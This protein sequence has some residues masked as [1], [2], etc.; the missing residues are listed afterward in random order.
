[1][2]EDVI[3]FDAAAGVFV[4]PRRR[5]CA[6]V[7]QRD[8]LFPHMSVRRNLAF[9]DWRSH[10]LERTRRVAEMLER[11]GLRAAAALRPSEVSPGERLRAELARALLASPK[12]LAIDERGL[13]QAAL[14]CVREIFSGPALVVTSDLDFC[15]AIAGDLLLLDGGKILQAG[16]A[17]AVIDH[18]ASVAAARLLGIP[19]LFECVVTALDPGRD[20]SRLE[21]GRFALAGPYLPGHFRGDRVTAAVR[22]DRVRV[23]S[24]EAERSANRVA[25]ELIRISPG[26]R[27][28]RLEFSGGIVAD[29]SHEEFARQKDNK[30]WQVEIP[31]EALRVV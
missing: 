19:N 28:V 29:V 24:G 17:R 1:L 25:A 30:S 9:A 13:D 18:P 2:L 7:P 27:H 26:S 16:D 6:Y 4:P 8:S 3:L 31:P 12:L 5:G 23:H 21:F 20:I 14:R 15:C 22:A 11:F 10:R